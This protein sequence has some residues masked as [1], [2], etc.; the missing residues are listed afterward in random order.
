M[1][2]MMIAFVLILFTGNIYAQ[3]DTAAILHKLDTLNNKV[4][5]IDTAISSINKTLSQK[6]FIDSAQLAKAKA[7]KD[8]YLYKNYF[9]NKGTAT[10]MQWFYFIVA[11]MVLLFIWIAGFSYAKSSGLCK[12]PSYDTNGKLL[13]PSVCSYSYARVQLFW[14]TMIILSAY[15]F[16]F[17]VTGFLL[18]INPT[19]V[20]LLGLGAVVYG[21]G[22]IIDNQQ[23]AANKGNRT[24]DTDAQN[25]AIE[26]KLL[27]DI[28]SDDNGISIHRFQAVIFNIVFGIGF[29]ACFIQSLNNAYPFI[30]YTYWQFALMGISSA[31]YLGLKA[32]ENNNNNSNPIG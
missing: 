17:G 21:A 8:N 30:D 25:T 19:I 22:K 10:A 32:S 2:K 24:Q 1:K 4:K 14:W 31:T 12:D 16:F 7:N 13:N 20:I 18:P 26:P 9:F 23:T 29:I 6:D 5:K 15:V 11:L 3:V 27:T 28:L